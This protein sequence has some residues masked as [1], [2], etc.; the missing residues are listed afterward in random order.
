MR[1]WFMASG[2]FVLIV[3]VAGLLWFSIESESV[4][5]A[6]DASV[7]LRISGCVDDALDLGKGDIDHIDVVRGSSIGCDVSIDGNYRGC[8]I[9]QGRHIPSA[10][11]PILA[12]MS[13]TVDRSSCERIS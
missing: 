9:L 7:E 1:G 8:L 3:I 13:K 4:P 5:I 2:I 6:N 12:T 10:P 11:I